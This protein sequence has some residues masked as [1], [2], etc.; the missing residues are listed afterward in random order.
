MSK[1]RDYADLRND[2]DDAAF[3]GNYSDLEGLPTIPTA[4]SQLT[5][6][7]GYLTSGATGPAGATGK[8]NVVSFASKY[9]FN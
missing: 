5:N 1:A 4:L 3:S 9:A 6:D 2:L 7:S 8:S